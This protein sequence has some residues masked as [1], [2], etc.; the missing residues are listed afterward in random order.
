MTSASAGT[1]SRNQ[2]MVP[3]LFHKN[4]GSAATDISKGTRQLTGTVIGVNYIYDEG[5]GGYSDEIDSYKI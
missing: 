1:T 2:P 4:W 5:E 3:L